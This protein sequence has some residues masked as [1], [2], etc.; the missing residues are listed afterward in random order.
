MK[1]DINF[2]HKQDPLDQFERNV[3]M[4]SFSDDLKIISCNETFEKT[5]G[6]SR[7]ALIGK[8][9]FLD[10]FKNL[11]VYTV[12]DISYTIKRG[13]N[14][15]GN[16]NLPVA[17]AQSSWFNI[18]IVPVNNK[19]GEKIGYSFVAAVGRSQSELISANTSSEDWLKAVLHDPEEAKILINTDG[20]IIEYN[21]AAFSFAEWY[22]N[23]SLSLDNSIYKYL[24][25]E[26]S[27]TLRAF[28]DKANKGVRQNFTRK[29][30]NAN[31]YKKTYDIELRPVFSSDMNAMGFVM[32]IVDITAQVELSNRI[33]KSEKRLNDIAF[34]AAHE[35]RAPLASIM[36]LVYLLDYEYVNPEGRQILDR[37][38]KASIDLDKIIHK[39]SESSY[40]GS[41]YPLQKPG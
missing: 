19:E 17:N 3:M 32:V 13:M 12:D 26:F 40:I 9:V 37:L 2:K 18:H 27:I 41:E 24:P 14:W 10:I 6:F 30:E 21:K 36:G 28:L 4:L 35:V 8:H 25:E 23:K 11:P 15:D 16:L 22:V 1:K 7:Q 20:L 5:T 33:E 29:F 31:G 34:I 38:K 39:V